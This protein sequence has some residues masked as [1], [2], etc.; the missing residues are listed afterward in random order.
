[1][2]NFFVEL[3]EGIFTPGPT[4]TILKAANISFASLQLVLFILLI[5]TYNIHCLI[6]SFI[7]AGL[8]I[9]INWFASELAAVQKEQ[10][11]QAKKKAEDEQQQEEEED[12]GSTTEVEN[13]DVKTSALQEKKGVVTQ[14]LGTQSS[15]STEDEWEKVSEAENEK[16]K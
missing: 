3:W 7:S 5:A 1:M 8:W 4:P 11:E 15:V 13:T 14:R 12:G 10:A 9:S 16:D 6:L 2:S